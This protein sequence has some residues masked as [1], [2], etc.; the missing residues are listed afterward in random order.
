MLGGAATYSE[1]A[2]HITPSGNIIRSAKTVLLSKWPSPSASSR[3][4]MRCGFFWSCS[5]TLSLEPDE[6]ATYSRPCPSKSATI[7]RLTSG[8]P[9]TSSTSKPA[10]SVK[11][12]PFNS[13]WRTE[14]F[15]ASPAGGAATRTQE[16]ATDRKTL[17]RASR[18]MRI[19]PKGGNDGVGGMLPPASL[20]PAALLVRAGRD[21][22]GGDQERPRGDG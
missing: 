14:G 19:S 22:V 21:A 11:V 13:T 4:T 8:G 15:F 17:A 20:L 9:A 7:G 10:G 3:R 6:S 16:P 1:P 5:C 2:C 12:W 18:F